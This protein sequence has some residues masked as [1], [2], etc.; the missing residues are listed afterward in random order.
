VV[1]DPCLTHVNGRLCGSTPH[2]TS[3]AV[4]LSGGGNNGRYTGDQCADIYMTG[5]L[6]YDAAIILPIVGVILVVGAL[7]ILASFTNP[8]RRAIAGKEGMR[9][10]L[11]RKGRSSVRAAEFDEE[12]EEI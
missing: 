3:F 1:Q 11:A 9:V 8:G 2:L 4:L 10:I 12:A 6:K 7:L 5:S